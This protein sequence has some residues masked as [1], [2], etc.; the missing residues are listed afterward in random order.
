MIRT[1]ALTKIYRGGVRALDGLDLAVRESEL[2]GFLGPNGAGKTT[3]V[4]LLIGAVAPSSGQASVLGRPLGDREARRNLGYLPEQFQFPGF[5]TPLS[6][7]DFHGR[8]QGMEVA[9]RRRRAAELVEMVGL[10][11]AAERQLKTFSKGM[12]QRVGLAQALLGRPRLLLLDE[13]TSGLDPIGTRNVRDLLLWLKG[14]GVAVLLNSHLLSEVELICDRVAI[15]NRGRIAA[16]GRLDEILNPVS[17][18]R[19][20]ARELSADGVRMLEAITASLAAEEGGWWRAK[21]ADP[22]DASRLAAAVVSSGAAL[23]ALVPTHETLEEAFLRLV[24]YEIPPP[25]PPRVPAQPA[26]GWGAPPA[27]IS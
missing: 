13:P 10:R 2:F 17:S 27:N 18:V 6:L 23:E 5:L 11:D 9:D 25:A 4:Q 15:I 14:E 22:A 21:L 16:E 7:L 24:G 19:I 20:R 12:L 1:T 3:T 8:L 26:T